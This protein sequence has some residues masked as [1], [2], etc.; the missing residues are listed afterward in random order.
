M[1]KEVEKKLTKLNKKLNNIFTPVKLMK[2]DGKDIEGVRCMRGKDGRL[3][4]SEK[5][6]REREMLE[7]AILTEE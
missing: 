6:R 2:K 5:D 3:G 4:F 1:R 7:S